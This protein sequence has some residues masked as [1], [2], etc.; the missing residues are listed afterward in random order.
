MSVSGKKGA[1]WCRRQF[2][3]SFNKEKLPVV[4]TSRLTPKRW[5]LLH[6]LGQE[7]GNNKMFNRYRIIF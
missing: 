4:S 6:D 7:Y 1:Y 5:K 3:E 2:L